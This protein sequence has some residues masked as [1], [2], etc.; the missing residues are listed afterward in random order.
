MKDTC[1]SK[2]SEDWEAVAA[3]VHGMAEMRLGAGVKTLAEQLQ[4]ALGE[5]CDVDAGF[6]EDMWTR[7]FEESIR[8]YQKRRTEAR[9][10]PDCTFASLNNLGRWSWINAALWAEPIAER[11]N[12]VSVREED[13]VYRKHTGQGDRTFATAYAVME[14]ERACEDG[15]ESLYPATTQ[16]ARQL[17]DLTDQI[18]GAGLKSAYR[19]LVK[20]WHPDHFEGAPERERSAAKERLAAVNHAYRLLQ[21]AVAGL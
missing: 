4:M 1:Y 7:G 10:I 5:G 16:E 13:V 12:A 2:L 19:R 21:T 15:L 8:G 14:S 11:F 18:T 9:P 3:P 17:L 6:F 20:K